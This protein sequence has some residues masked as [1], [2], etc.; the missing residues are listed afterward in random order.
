MGGFEASVVELTGDARPAVVDFHFAESLES[1]TYRWVRFLDG[2]YEPFE[3]PEFGQTVRL[4]APRGPL[5]MEGAESYDGRP[6]RRHQRIARKFRRR[7]ERRPAKLPKSHWL[8]PRRG[9]HG[10]Q[11]PNVRP[12]SL[13]QGR[14]RGR[15]RSVVPSHPESAWRLR[16]PRLTSRLLR[17]CSLLDLSVVRTTMAPDKPYKAEVPQR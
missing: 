11:P 12:A 6:R 10:G 5:E 17:H 8:A 15:R 16:S 3:P 9:P 13:R 2:I 14:G 1:P 7:R 4:E